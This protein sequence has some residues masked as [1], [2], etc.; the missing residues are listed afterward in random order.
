VLNITGRCLFKY[1]G[2]TLAEADFWS[3][4]KADALMAA[5]ARGIGTAYA[6]EI[7]ALFGAS[8]DDD[9]VNAARHI[10]GTCWMTAYHSEQRARSAAGGHEEHSNSSASDTNADKSNN[11]RGYKAGRE[12][13]AD[14]ATR[15]QDEIASTCASR[16]TQMIRSG[17]YAKRSP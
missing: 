8:G 6:E 4:N 1:S 14:G 3:R 16:A 2:M 12:A 17:D 9:I 10:V 13:A 11:E 15:Q 5:R 7:G